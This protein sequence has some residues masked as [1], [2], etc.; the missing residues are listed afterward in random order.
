MNRE[1]NVMKFIKQKM[2]IMKI[3]INVINNV[4]IYR[5]YIITIKK[6]IS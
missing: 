2:K 5:H 3:I 6:K 4:N 1:K